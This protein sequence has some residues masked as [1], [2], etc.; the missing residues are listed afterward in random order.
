MA[1]LPI[2]ISPLFMQRLEQLITEELQN[3][4]SGKLLW[5]FVTVEPFHYPVD[6]KAL[7]LLDYPKIVHYP[8]DLSTIKVTD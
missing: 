2:D 1:T 7:F 5:W 6:W 4:Q 3:P 8:M